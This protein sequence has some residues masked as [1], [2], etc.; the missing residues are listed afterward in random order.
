MLNFVYRS[1]AG[2]EQGLAKEALSSTDKDGNSILH[3][4]V[5]SGS[6]EV[7]L[8]YAYL[9]HCRNLFLVY[10]A[11]LSTSPCKDKYLDNIQVLLLEKDIHK[12]SLFW[13]T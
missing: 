13:P 5:N 12:A 1:I 11:A 2:V 3:A 9:Q 6:L 4:A 8:I 10:S 7:G